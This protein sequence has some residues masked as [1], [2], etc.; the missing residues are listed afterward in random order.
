[1]SSNPSENISDEST[2]YRDFDGDE[3]KYELETTFPNGYFDVIK[4]FTV[5]K[6]SLGQI[7]TEGKN[8]GLN[9]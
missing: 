9:A 5:G 6:Y 3:K 4:K 2:I 1:M 8:L 7:V